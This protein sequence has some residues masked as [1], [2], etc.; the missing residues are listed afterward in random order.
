M[1]DSAGKGGWR[2]FPRGIGAQIAAL[3][4]VS[5]LLI[6]GFALLWLF[7]VGADVPRGPPDHRLHREMAAIWLLDRTAPDARDALLAGLR[8]S[9]PDL[10]I[11]PA[12]PAP[13]GLDWSSRDKPRELTSGIARQFGTAVVPPRPEDDSDTRTIAFRLSDGTVYLAVSNERQPPPFGGPAV[14]TLVFLGVTLTVL[15]LWAAFAVAKPLRRF[16]DAVEEFG[17]DGVEP[18]ALTEEGP[19]EVRRAARAFNRMQ[20]R[21]NKLVQDRIR[22]LAA[23]GHDLRTPVTRLKLRSDY[24]QDDKLRGELLGDLDHM[25]RLLKGALTY[26]SDGRSG[27]QTVVVDLPSL[28]STISDQWS[29]RDVAV[30]FEGPTGIRVSGR[31]TELMRLFGN[32]VDNAVGHGGGGRIVLFVDAD[33]VQIDVIDTGPGIA[34]DQKDTMLAAFTRG[35]TARSVRAETGFGLGLAICEAIAKGHGGSLSLLDTPG[36]GLTARVVLPRAGGA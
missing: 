9:D 26:L 12:D 4:V 27:E 21:I 30:P 11:R 7:G 19:D 25:D 32:L 1:N 10:A 28:L 23:V 3:L 22:M 20:E 24:V 18:V 13:E 16:S 15:G 2:L 6:H 14:T 34:S 33:R 8:D 17:R 35:D 29:D 36:G 5:L 31:P